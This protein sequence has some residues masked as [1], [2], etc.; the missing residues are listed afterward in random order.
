MCIRDSVYL[1]LAIQNHEWN[2]W[3]TCFFLPNITLP[4]RPYLGF[5]ASTGDVTDAHDIVS[6]STNSIVYTSHASKEFVAERNRFFKD[7]EKAAKG[8]SWFGWLFGSGKKSEKSYTPPPPPRPRASS[9]FIGGFFSFIGWLLRWAIILAFI[10]AAA[11][12]AM[13]YILSLIHI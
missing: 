13:H 7:R 9:S 1:E 11:A 2:Q 12:F 10:G 5:S 3:S 4:E 8:K 6:I